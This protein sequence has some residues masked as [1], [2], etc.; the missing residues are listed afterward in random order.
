M[1]KSE[2]RKIYKDKRYRLSV[3]DQEKLTDRILISFQKIRLPFLNCVHT[4][5]ASEK[6]AEPDTSQ[7][8]RFLQFKN[9]GL[10]V[11][12]PR[13]DTQAGTMEHVVSDDGTEWVSNAFGISEPTGGGTVAQEEIDLVLV[14][15]LAVDWNGYRVGYGKGYYDKFLSECRDDVITVGISFFEPV[16]PIEDIDQF[17]ISLD[18]CVTPQS[19]LEF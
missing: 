14:P 17:D 16:D 18:Y 5:I 9:P 2:L 12:V 8:I 13:V 4:Y 11:I 10:I 3:Q 1:K 7:M 15:L 6:L 19:V